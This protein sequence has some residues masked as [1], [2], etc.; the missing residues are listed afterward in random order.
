MIYSSCWCNIWPLAQA[1]QHCQKMPWL[2]LG[3]EQQTF[4]LVLHAQQ[5]NHL[6][7]TPRSRKNQL[8]KLVADTAP[9]NSMCG[10]SSVSTFHFLLTDKSPCHL[11]PLQF[12]S[13]CACMGILSPH[14]P[15][16]NTHM[17]QFHQVKPPYRDHLG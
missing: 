8:W 10:H 11:R 2:S 15:Y 5:R 7:S 4:Y 6:L 3:N 14:I 1:T 12:R 17:T 13:L 9:D 16:H